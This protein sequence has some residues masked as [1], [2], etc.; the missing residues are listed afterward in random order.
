M[1]SSSPQDWRAGARFRDVDRREGR[2]GPGAC[3]RRALVATATARRRIDD[4]HVDV[5]PEGWM[6][7]MRNL[8]TCR[9]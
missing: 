4:Y 9:E 1:A 3:G 5:A 7:V 6:L 2:H 8:A